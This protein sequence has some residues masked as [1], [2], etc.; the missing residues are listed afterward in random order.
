[1]LVCHLLLMTYVS[2]LSWKLYD[3]SE[4]RTILRTSGCLLGLEIF[5][6]CEDLLVALT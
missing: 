6:A 5:R 3:S 4:P 2:K 1:M